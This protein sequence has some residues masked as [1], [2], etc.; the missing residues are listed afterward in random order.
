MPAI[1][2]MCERWEELLQPYR[3]SQQGPILDAINPERNPFVT[4][5]DRI[6]FSSS[7]RRLSKKTQ[8]HPL[9]QNDHIHNRLT[10]SLEVSCVGKTLGT[11]VGYFLN[12]INALP[13]SFRPENMG[14]IVQAAC[15]AHDIGNP[16]FG[17]AGESAIQDWFKDPINNEYISPL[18]PNEQSDFQAIDGNAQ[19]FRVVNALEN[20]K[21]RGGLRLT[22]PTL[23]AMVKYPNSSHQAV[24]RNSTKFSYYQEEETLFKEIFSTLNLS[25]N[26][27]VS[28]HPLS[29]LSEA[30][31][32]ICYRIID[33]E[34]ARELGIISMDDIL[35]ATVPLATKH[36][37]DLDKLASMDSDR[38][39]AGMIR[40][41]V[42][43]SLMDEIVSVFKTQHEAIISSTHQG[44]IIDL[45][46]EAAREYMKNAKNVFYE[47][48]IKD[49]KKTALEI[50]SYSLY[51]RLL[52]TFIPACY[53]QCMNIPLSYKQ[54]RA[55]SLMGV[56]AP[57]PH[58]QLYTSH[59]K[60]L[61]F[62]T[63]MTDSYA[64]FISKQFSGTAQ[65]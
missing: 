56:N 46:D 64:T 15:L 59:L 33:L 27:T 1:T 32:D 62:I 61:D 40:T 25:G 60:A 3:F 63:G 2:S 57:E 20:N 36:R 45:V 65:N 48:I 10:H 4:D 18:R 26:G 35:Q 39:R 34:D 41:L 43:G 7:F 44:P 58:D 13:A 6:L 23:A 21:Y 37:W 52:D 24:G 38:R 54:K 8:V 12:S 55:L 11:K 31:D 17:H 16:P 5:Y 51:K 9:A 19:G 14:E 28:R 50:G 30:A 49:P 47:K 53:N 29:Y 22:F 42:I